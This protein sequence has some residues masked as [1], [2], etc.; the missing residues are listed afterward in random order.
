MGDLL[1]H[2]VSP[3]LFT[4]VDLQ[5]CHRAVL[6][7]SV[8]VR[9]LCMIDET[10]RTT[11]EKKNVYK[12]RLHW[13]NEEKIEKKK[14]QEKRNTTKEMCV[15]FGF[16]AHSAIHNTVRGNE[17]GASSP[18]PAVDRFSHGQAPR[19]AETPSTR[20]LVVP[21]TGGEAGD[22]ARVEPHGVSDVQ[23]DERTR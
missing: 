10:T 1:L 14:T 11:S 20:R 12:G 7:R 16:A 3:N 19:A 2:T 9:W 4:I 21:A 22:G 8:D 13:E 5:T 17:E 6:T 18:R 23:E 15:G